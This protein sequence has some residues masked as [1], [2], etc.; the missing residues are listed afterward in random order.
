MTDLREYR[1]RFGALRH[2]CHLI[3]NS[4]GAMPDAARDW[5]LRYI[6]AWSRR[7]VRSWEEH[8]WSLGR[9]V[10]DKIGA[11][12]G[13][14]PDTVS[15]HPNVTSAEATVLSCFEVR[16]PRDKVVAVEMEFPSILYLYREWLRGRGRLEIV[17][18]PDGIT[19]PTE[20]LLAAI[21]ETTL[22]VPIS[23]VLFRSSCIVD[24]RA[25]IERAHAVGAKVVLDVFQSLGTVPVDLQDLDV[26]FAVGGCLKWLCGGPGACFLYVRPDLADRLEPRFTG[27]LAH[28]DPFAFDPGPL[29]RTRGSYRFQSGTPNIPALYICQA[30]LDIVGEVGVGAIREHSLALT[31]HLLSLARARSWPTTV[32]ASAARRGGTV[33]LNLPRAEEITAILGS[34]DFLVD[35]RPRAGIRVSPHFYNTTEEIDR[36]VRAIEEIEGELGP[37]ARASAAPTGEPST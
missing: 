31:D 36:L 33:A 10:G 21:D 4:L 37:A 34:R 25:V 22:L 17:P 1:A 35:Y 30:G 8:W 13:A 7:S 14:A 28:D 24:A 3:S 23:H 12:A 19:V 20:R 27:W 5:A 15:M 9:T 11:L 32:P 26:D 6:E 18:C 29:V 16:P 2:A